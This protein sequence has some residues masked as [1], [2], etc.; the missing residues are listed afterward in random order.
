MTFFPLRTCEI[1]SFFFFF[2]FHYHFFTSLANVGGSPAR[3][4]PKMAVME[5]FRYIFFFIKNVK[6]VIRSF[7]AILFPGC[8]LTHESSGTFERS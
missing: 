3:S 5:R 4:L 2:Y 8:M 6:S 1:P 7:E